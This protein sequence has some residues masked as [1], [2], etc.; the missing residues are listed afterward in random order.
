MRY[1][2]QRYGYYY[3]WFCQQLVTLKQKDLDAKGLTVD[4][5]QGDLDNNVYRP[6]EASVDGPDK[7]KDAGEDPD[8]K[9]ADKTEGSNTTVDNDVCATDPVNEVTGSLLL[10]YDDFQLRDVRETF[11]LKRIYESVHQNKGMLLGSKWFLS[12]ESRVA[13]VGDDIQVQLPDMHVVK[14]HKNAEGIWENKK[15]GDRSRIHTIDWL[16][17]K[18]DL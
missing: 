15:G 7:P 4:D 6:K 13:R 18:I 10:D 14:F 1:Q 5:I 3:L 12:I 2:W 11:L 17:R 8:N 16:K 9:P